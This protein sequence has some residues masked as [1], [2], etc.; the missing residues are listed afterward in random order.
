MRFTGRKSKKET[1]TKKSFQKI[2]KKANAVVHNNCSGESLWKIFKDVRTQ[3][4]IRKS[5]ICIK[6]CKMILKLL[7]LAEIIGTNTYD[8]RSKS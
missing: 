4:W 1:K 3:N 2:H 6:G 5:N 8:G 7:L